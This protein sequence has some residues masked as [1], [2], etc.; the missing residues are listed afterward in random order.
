MARLRADL[1]EMRADAILKGVRKGR[2]ERSLKSPV[3]LPLVNIL[4]SQRSVARDEV[5]KLIGA[6]TN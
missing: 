5:A 2:E 3:E 4:G 1:R 6:E